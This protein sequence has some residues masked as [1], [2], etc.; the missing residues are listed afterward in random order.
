VAFLRARHVAKTAEAVEAATG[1]SAATVKNWLAGVAQPGGDAMARLALA[2]GPDFLLAMTDR[3]PAWL[4]DAVR[5]QR[6]T[7]LEAAQRHLD[8]A[9]SAMGAR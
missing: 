6:Q 4:S 9:I 7:E 5:A 2:Y 8:A 3:A 1:I